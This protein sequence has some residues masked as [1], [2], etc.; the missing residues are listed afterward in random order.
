MLTVLMDAAYSFCN[1]CDVARGDLSSINNFQSTGNFQRL[2]GKVVIFCQVLVNKSITSYST[3]N[4][5]MGADFLVIDVKSTINNEMVSI[6]QFF[7]NGYI[8]DSSAGNRE[9]IC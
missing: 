7:L 9:Y 5:G 3:I 8:L 6:E 2:Q 1:V 4:Q